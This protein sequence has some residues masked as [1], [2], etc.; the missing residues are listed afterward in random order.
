MPIINVQR[1]FAAG[2]SAQ[3]TPTFSQ[4]AQDD[5]GTTNYNT[6]TFSGVSWANPEA[7]RVIAVF[8]HYYVGNTGGTPDQTVSSATI[9]GT[10]ATVINSGVSG[11]FDNTALIAAVLATGTSG[12][13][14]VNW[15]G[16][17]V[18]SAIGVWEI[19]GA[20]GVTPAATDPDNSDPS[21]GESL[22]VDI[23]ANGCAIAA[24]TSGFASRPRTWTG[25]TEQYD[26]DGVEGVSALMSF[27]GADVQPTG[28]L[29]SAH[30]ISTSYSSDNRG[31]SGIAASW[32][33]A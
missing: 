11:Q 16:D 4:Y 5:G 21:T 25:A 13:V 30:A 8:V 20:D 3:A 23:P 10:S 14:V 9:G 7:G 18:V 33:A 24:S 17:V 22:A 28:T 15:S 32:A 1:R 2:G 12:D 27:S 29:R 31:G 6:Y 19:S 26:T